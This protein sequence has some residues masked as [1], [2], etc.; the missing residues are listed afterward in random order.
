MDRGVHITKTYHAIDAMP[1]SCQNFGH[2]Q[3][4]PC[5]ANARICHAINAMPTSEFIT[6]LMQ[7]QLHATIRPLPELVDQCQNSSING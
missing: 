3:D 2:R 5:N 1:T 4:L 6:Q 7:C